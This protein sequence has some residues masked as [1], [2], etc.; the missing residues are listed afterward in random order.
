MDEEQLD[1]AFAAFDEALANVRALMAEGQEYGAGASLDEWMMRLR[2]AVQ[3]IGLCQPAREDR[4]MLS[5]VG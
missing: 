5:P 4:R 2:V 1:Q 3:M